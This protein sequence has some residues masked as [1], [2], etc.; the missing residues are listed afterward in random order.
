MRRHPGRRAAIRRSAARRDG[1]HRDGRAPRWTPP[2]M[3]GGRRLPSVL[4]STVN[5]VPSAPTGGMYGN[6][7]PS[8][9]CVCLL[10]RLATS[11]LL[12]CGLA[13]TCSGVPRVLPACTIQEPREVP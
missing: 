7:H 8:L 4:L 13:D 12:R 9:S 5:T 10:H 1:V 3:S 6:Y 11:A 2:V